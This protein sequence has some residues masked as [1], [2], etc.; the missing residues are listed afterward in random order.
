M[1]ATTMNHAHVANFGEPDVFSVKQS[2]IP[3]PKE[4]EAL[5]N[6]VTAGLN[7]ADTLQRRG[8]YPP[9]PGCSEI[10]GL[11]VAGYLCD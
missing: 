11:E 4:G 6:V 3:V 8:K 5:I 2:E 9:P 10:L 1:K 7:R